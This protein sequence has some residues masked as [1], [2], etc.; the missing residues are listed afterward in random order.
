MSINSSTETLTEA[1]KRALRALRRDGRLFAR[2][3]AWQGGTQRTYN[4]ATLQALVDA[5]AGRWAQLQIG[6]RRLDAVVLRDAA[7]A[8]DGRSGS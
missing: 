3:A 1:Q 5:G 4:K 6:G 2:A 7:D 8:D